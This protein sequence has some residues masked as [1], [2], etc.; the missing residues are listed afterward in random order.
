[1]N[2][3]SGKGDSG[4]PIMRHRVSIKKRL[5]VSAAGWRCVFSS[6]SGGFKLRC[7]KNPGW[8]LLSKPTQCLVIGLHALISPSGE[9]SDAASHP[10]GG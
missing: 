8:G 9:T 5:E 4:L 10:T 6:Q 7:R 1:M 2:Q 3:E